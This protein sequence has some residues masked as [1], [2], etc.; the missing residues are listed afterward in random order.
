MKT[1][2]ILEIDSIT[3]LSWRIGEFEQTAQQNWITVFS[4]ALSV[5][6]TAVEIYR[7]MINN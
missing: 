4:T 6:E 2:D 7:L 3:A 5:Y 1:E